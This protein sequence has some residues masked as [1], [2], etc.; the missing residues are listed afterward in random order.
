MYRPPEIVDPYLKYKVS[1]KVDLWMLG[2]IL[3]TMSYFTHPFVEANAVGIANAVFRFPNY[4][5]E[6][7]Y[8]VSQKIQDYIRNFLTPNP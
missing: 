4:P 3:Y 7:K 2:C 5:S 8:Q 6:T 1:G